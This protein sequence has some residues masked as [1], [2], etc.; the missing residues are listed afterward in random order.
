MSVLS[1]HLLYDTGRVPDPG[2]GLRRG[3]VP[4]YLVCASDGV[5]LGFTFMREH[6]VYAWHRHTTDGIVESVC[7]IPEPDGAG[8]YI[9]AVYLIVNRTINGATKRYVERMVDRV[10]ATIAD[11]W[12]LDCALQ[13]SGAPV[14][15][16]WG[17]VISRASR[18]RS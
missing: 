14:T 10:F 4:N 6:E 12:F 3:A 9:D 7:S 1:Q 17:L 16:V 8:G 18:W 15:Q 13:Y 2:M 11:T 5:L